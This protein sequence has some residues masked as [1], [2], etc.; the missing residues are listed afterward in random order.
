MRITGATGPNMDIVN[1][2]YEPTGEEYNGRVLFR[3]NGD[4]SSWLL[5]TKSEN[6]VV[7]KTGSKD[8]KDGMGLFVSEKI[9]LQHPTSEPGWKIHNRNKWEVQPSVTVR[10]EHYPSA[11]APDK[12][13][14]LDREGAAATG[15]SRHRSPSA[16]IHRL[17]SSTVSLHP[18]SLHPN[19][20]VDGNCGIGCSLYGV[21]YRKHDTV[22]YSSTPRF[23]H[24]MS[25]VGTPRFNKEQAHSEEPKLFLKNFSDVCADTSTVRDYMQDG[26]M[27]ERRD[28]KRHRELQQ[29]LG[30]NAA[31]NHNWQQHS[32]TRSSIRRRAW[33]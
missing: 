33:F 10:R 29:Q 31:H 26:V 2:L 20:W 9:G 14:Y 25:R 17:W 6:W 30:A 23:S 11:L 27:K 16:K 8:A 5:Y 18:N 28:A 1:G 32:A 15:A 22:I 24:G 12:A 13:T 4:S 19:L 21:V 7:T 3:K